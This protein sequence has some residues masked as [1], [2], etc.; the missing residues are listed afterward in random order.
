MDAEDAFIISQHGW[1]GVMSPKGDGWGGCKRHWLPL[2]GKLS[3]VRLTDEV[4]A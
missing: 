1:L 3:A 4:K 2:E